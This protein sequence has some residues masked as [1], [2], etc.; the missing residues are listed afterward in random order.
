MTREI[1]VQWLMKAE[2]SLNDAKLLLE[3]SSSEGACSRASSAIF[4]LARAALTEN[5][6]AYR[7]YDAEDHQQ[8][9]KLF[10]DT[11]VRTKKCDLNLFH[12]LRT[13]EHFKEVTEKGVDRYFT[14]MD[15]E[16]IIAHADRMHAFV[17]EQFAPASAPTI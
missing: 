5:D 4:Q 13:A 17:N 9:M 1:T 8:I 16:K 7:T 12:A 11:F 2:R 14:L 10:A 6:S 3:N 15:A